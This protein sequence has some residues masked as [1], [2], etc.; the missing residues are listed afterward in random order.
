MINSEFAKPSCAGSLII[1]ALLS[2][3]DGVRET[4]S[5]KYIARCPAHDDRSPS[6]AITSCDD[7][8]IL[9]H[10]FAGCETEDVLTAI[11]LTFADLMPE[12]IGSEHRYKPVRQRFDAKQVLATLDHESLVVAIIG[13]DIQD[14]REIDDPTWSRLSEAVQRINDSRAL[15]A[16]LRYRK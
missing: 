7:G 1:D 13:A 6:L 11:G 15:V 8:R 10:C 16:P 12:R 3:L 4:G 9:I 2:R 14:H 5:G